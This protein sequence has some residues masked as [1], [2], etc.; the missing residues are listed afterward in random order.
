MADY[1]LSNKAD[2]DLDEIYVY[3]YRTF[4]EAKADAYF[5]SLRD[6]LQTLADNPHLG[7]FAGQIQPELRCHRHAGHMVFYMVEPTGIFV[8]RV[9]HY[10]MDTPSHLNPAGNG[11]H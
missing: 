5:L 7:C 8:I 9:L 1:V 11:E 4:G 3:S 2:A 6:C 10:A